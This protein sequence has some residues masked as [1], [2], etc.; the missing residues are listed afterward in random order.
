MDGAVGCVQP[1]ICRFPVVPR[2]GGDVSRRSVSR[3]ARGPDAG[4]RAQGAWGIRPV[5]GKL[6]AGHSQHLAG[7]KAWFLPDIDFSTPSSARMYD[8]YLGGKDNFPADR[9]AAEKAMSVV[10]Q[11]RAVA[12]ANRRFLIRAV[13]YLARNG[14]T[15]FID[16]GTGIPTSPNVHE[17]ARRIVPEARD[18]RAG[19]PRAAGVPLAHLRARFTGPRARHM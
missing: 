10:P 16:L 4:S 3:C 13:K 9:E 17:V 6:S 7:R 11:S 15:Q 8:Y 5:S 1:E 19:E 2:A 14:I 18:D 12:W